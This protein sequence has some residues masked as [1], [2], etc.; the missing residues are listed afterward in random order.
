[1]LRVGKVT[2][3]EGSTSFRLTPQKYVELFKRFNA[4]LK[5]KQES[6]TLDNLEIIELII[7]KGNLLSFK[8]IFYNWQKEI[9]Q[10]DFSIKKEDSPKLKPMIDAA[11][12]SVKLL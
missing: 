8:I 6:I 12:K 9:I 11:I 4:N 5:I 3:K 7:E 10:L 1:L 2:L